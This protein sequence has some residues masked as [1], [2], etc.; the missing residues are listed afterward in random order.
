MWQEVWLLTIRITV[1]GFPTSNTKY[2]H[3]WWK[4]MLDQFFVSILSIVSIWKQKDQY[5]PINTFQ[6]DI[7]I[8]QL[9]GLE[10]TLLSKLP[11]IWVEQ[12]LKT[13]MSPF[14]NCC[15]RFLALFVII[16]WHSGADGRIEIILLKTIY[17]M[18]YQATI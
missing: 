4:W 16:N 15:Q 11:H 6:I 5:K 3:F 13:I 18:K 2:W 7:S 1:M 17:N 9:L 10:R 8:W 14:T 12:V